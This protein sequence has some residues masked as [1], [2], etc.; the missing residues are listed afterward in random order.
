MTDFIAVYDLKKTT[1]SPY[2]EF[3]NQAENRGWSRWIWGPKNGKWLKLPN[4]TL[5]GDFSSAEAAKNAFDQ[6]VAAAGQAIGLKVVVEKHLI[7][8]YEAR[9]Y[10]SDEKADS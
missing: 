9:S 2:S 10:S 6:A 3:I 8:T 4:T 1:P 7:A 5:I